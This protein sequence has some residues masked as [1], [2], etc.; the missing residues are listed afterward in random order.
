MLRI[1]DIQD[2]CVDWSQV[3]FCEIEE[4]DIEKYKLLQNDLVF[5]RTGAT[6]GKSFQIN[7]I[8]EISVYASYL[9]RVRP[10]NDKISDYLKHFFKSSDYWSQI[11]DLSAGIGQPN[12]NGSKLKNLKIPLAPEN[13]QRRIAEKLD[14]TLARVDALNDRLARITPLLKRFRQSVLAA[15]TSGRL[16][17]DWRCSNEIKGLKLGQNILDIPRE[18]NCDFL[19]SIINP[20]RPLCYGVVQPGEDCS[21]GIPLIRVQDMERGNVSLCGLRN[22]SEEID[23]EFKRSRVREGDLIISI[24]GTIGR[25][26]LVPK[27]FHGNI[28]RA[29][30]RLS[31]IEGVITKWIF[32]WLQSPEVHWWLVSSS[33][34][35]ARKT[36][37]LGDLA[38]LSV[39]LPSSEEQTEIVRRVEMLFAFADRLEARLQSAQTA[40]E[41]LTP[42]LLAKAFR[43]E[44]VPQDPSDEPAAE[45][46]RRL[47]E[48]RAADTASKPKRGRAAKAPTVSE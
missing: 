37:N 46:L 3:P 21:T 32:Y 14:T 16:T 39:A 4:K 7:I 17:E 48:A 6:V 19:G 44:L 28:A 26:A 29:I 1:T 12:V 9:I 41:R 18:W 34:E 5:A 8:N 15:A 10:I 11:T 24:V 38:Q 40:A 25:V 42:A 30:A 27:E 22:I 31:F 2:G 23:S 13:E 20:S 36:L 33:K 47:R 45:L 35:V 43:G